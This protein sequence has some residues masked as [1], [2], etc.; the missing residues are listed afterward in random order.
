MEPSPTVVDR[1]VLN[2]DVV[3]VTTSKNDVALD[4]HFCLL[5]WGIVEVG[6]LI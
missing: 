2:H 1:V 6:Y 4:T 5:V 3:G